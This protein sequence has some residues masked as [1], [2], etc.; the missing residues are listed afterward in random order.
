[1]TMKRI[2][3]SRVAEKVEVGDFHDWFVH[4]FG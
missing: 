2:M 3:E 1:M 4:T